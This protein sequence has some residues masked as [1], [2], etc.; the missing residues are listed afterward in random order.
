M[1]HGFSPNDNVFEA[2]D[3]SEDAHMYFNK[4]SFDTSF[5]GASLNPFANDLGQNT[6]MLPNMNHELPSDSLQT[7][8]KPKNDGTSSL[9]MTG[10]PGKSQ[11][12]LSI[13]VV[14]S[15]DLLAVYHLPMLAIRTI[16]VMEFETIHKQDAFP[17]ALDSI[18]DVSR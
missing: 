6:Y 15:S 8:E 2:K 13:F 9:D 3:N 7:A 18:R 12:Q 4:S 1:E 11:D 5:E 16:M 10:Q 14:I 17:I